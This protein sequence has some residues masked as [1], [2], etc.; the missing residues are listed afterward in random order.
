MNEE[1]GVHSARARYQEVILVAYNESFISGEKKIDVAP[2]TQC[3]IPNPAIQ[4][5]TTSCRSKKDILS[6]FYRLFVGSKQKLA[7]LYVV[8]L[9]IKSIVMGFLLTFHNI[10]EYFNLSQLI[11]G[12]SAAL[13]WSFLKYLRCGNYVYVFYLTGYVLFCPV[14]GL[15]CQCKLNKISPR[16]YLN[17]II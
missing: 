13:G 5:E 3:S 7:S 15:I 6:A 2:N 8:S 1:H 16:P 17:S 14:V 10:N 4:H 12:G 9:Y 11:V